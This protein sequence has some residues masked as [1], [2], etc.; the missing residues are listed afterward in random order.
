M[1][2]IH[3]NISILIYTLIIII[4][5]SNNCSSNNNNIQINVKNYFIKQ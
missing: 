3:N 2:N 4:I 1:I 5:F